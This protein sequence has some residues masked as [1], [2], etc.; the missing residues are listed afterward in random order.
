MNDIIHR[1][2]RDKQVAVLWVTHDKDEIQHADKVITLTPSAGE[3]QE[4]RYERA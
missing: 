4:A 1:Y 2:V 3:M